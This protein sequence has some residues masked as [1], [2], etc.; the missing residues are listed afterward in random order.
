M[1]QPIQFFTSLLCPYCKPV[2]YLIEKEK[3]Y[4]TTRLIDLMKEEHLSEEYTLINP[5]QRVPALKDGDFLLFESSTLMKYICNSRNVSDHWYPKDPK[6]RA[7]VDLYVDFH[8]QNSWDLARYNY[9]ILGNA[10]ETLE[11]AK[12]ISDEAF[13]RF[14][15]IFLSKT[16]FITSNDSLSIADLALVWHIAGLISSGYKLSARVQKYYDDIL[17]CDPEGFKQSIDSFLAE[18]EI[19]IKNRQ[20]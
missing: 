8:I 15:A 13:S 1:N 3:I 4:N 5:F 12:K 2:E 9:V 19:A 17:S 7:L 11:E 14:E 18:R 6:L 20:K 10:I 16:K